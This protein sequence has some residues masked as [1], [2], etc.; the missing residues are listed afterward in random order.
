MIKTK[1]HQPDYIIIANLAI[2]IVLGLF[3]L[4]SSSYFTACE[5]F[6]NC[7]FYL[8]HQ[9]LNGLLPG[10]FIFWLLARFDYH[11]LKKISLYLLIFSLIILALVLVP[12]IGFAKEGVS[13]WIKIGGLNFQPSEFIKLSFLIYLAAWFSNHQDKFKSIKEVFIPFIL[14]L[15]IISV[16]IIFQPDIGTL[17]VIIVSAMI[18]YFVAGA[19]WKHLGLIIMGGLISL[20]ALIKIAPYRFDRVM[21]FLHPEADPQGIG[22]HINQAILAI[23]SGGI[24][25]RGLGHS[26]QKINYLPEVVGDSIF[27]VMAEELGFI[28]MLIVVGLYIY[29]AIRIFRLAN[30]NRDNFGRLLTVG[31]GSWFIFQSLINMAAMLRLLPLTGIPLPFISYGGTSFCVFMAAFGILVNISK[32]TDGVDIKEKIC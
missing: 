3:I 30:L 21:V 31:I 18:V 27:A 11:H 15:V 12:G 17:L 9:L 8:K 25:G 24:F 14:F 7:Y 23:G 16:L 32:Q 1:I 6:N 20:V 28:K 19:P 10:L 13:R 26:Y 2:L 5:K 29:L 4:T 22:Y